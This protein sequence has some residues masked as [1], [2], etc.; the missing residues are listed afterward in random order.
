MKFPAIQNPRPLTVSP[1]LLVT[2][3]AP[4]ASPKVAPSRSRLGSVSP[5]RG[6]SRR[7]FSLVEVLLAIMI[8]GIGLIMVASVFPVGANWT[9]QSA[10]ESVGQNIAQDALSVI[11]RHYGPGG[12]MYINMPNGKQE[13]YLGSDYLLAP[14]TANN[15]CL[16]TVLRGGTSAF[17][18]QALPGFAAPPLGLSNAAYIPVT[19]RAYQLGNQS[20]F[21][22][23]NPL[24][25]TY[26]W[27]ALIRLDPSYF[28]PTVGG[29]SPTNNII[30]S[31]SYKYDVYI[32]VFHKGEATQRFTTATG[33]EMPGTRVVT[34]PLTGLNE[35]I[36]PSV[37]G[38]SQALAAQ[39]PVGTTIV[40]DW[41]GTVSHVA[42]GKNGAAF[43]PPLGVVPNITPQLPLGPETILYSPSADN[44]ATSPLI[45]VYQTTLT[46]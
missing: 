13:W 19:E 43:L 31:P 27:T 33:I 39:F 41:T 34:D 30:P 29:P 38:T 36:F 6:F 44:T 21:P 15:F 25:C 11:Q 10:E 5:R 14:G 40:G 9:R 24:I 16:N 37:Y 26:F 17:T 12:D 18:L 23:V 2:M 1:C 46:F 7:A 28:V 32:L 35:S 22:A 4:S 45:Y 42:I 8:L 20:P 3:S